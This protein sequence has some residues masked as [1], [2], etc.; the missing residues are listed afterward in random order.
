MQDLTLIHEVLDRAGD[1]LDRHLRVDTVLVEQVDA[2]GA[3]ALERT[4][5]RELDVFRPAIQARA[6]LAGLK[7]DVPAELRGDHDLVAERRDG[8]AQNPLT[9]MRAIRFGGVEKRDA[10]VEGGCG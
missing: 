8:F 2:I 4:L 7:V 1:I 6:P 5:D 3:K 10:A 9:L